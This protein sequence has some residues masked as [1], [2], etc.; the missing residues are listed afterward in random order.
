MLNT[1]SHL[2]MALICCWWLHPAQVEA[3]GQGVR[4]SEGPGILSTK[5]DKTDRAEILRLLNEGKRLR[6]TQTGAAYDSAFAVLDSA[7][8]LAESRFGHSDST[9]AAAL[10]GLANCYSWLGDAALRDSLLEEAK[11]IWQRAYGDQSPPVAAAITSQAFFLPPQGKLLQAEEQFTRAIHI[12][13]NSSGTYYEELAQ[14]QH[15]LGWVALNLDRIPQADSMCR[16]AL[17]NWIRFGGDRCWGAGTEHLQLGVI[18]RSAG[19][20]AEAEQHLRL[21]LDILMD[22]GPSEN[23]LI[24]VVQTEF[25]SLFE[26]QQRFRE[27]Q[28]YFERAVLSIERTFTPTA[29]RLVLPLT[30]LAQCERNTGSLSQAR[31][32]YERALEISRDGGSVPDQPLQMSILGDLAEVE[33]LL[34]DVQKSV[35]Y[36]ESSAAS[37]QQFLRDVFSF[38]PEDLKLQFAQQY[39]PISDQLLT[40]A[41]SKH[42]AAAIRPA[43]EMV[44]KGKALLLDA[45]TEQRAAVYCSGD[46]T[47]IRLEQ[48]RADICG[49]IAGLSHSSGQGPL[50]NRLADSL[51]RMYHVKDSLELRLGELCETFRDVKGMSQ[52]TLNDVARSLEAGTA[53]C[54]FVSYQP[55]PF[56][57]WGDASR[58]TKH[59]GVFAIS[60]DGRVASAD[61]GPSHSIDSLVRECHTSIDSYLSASQNTSERAAEQSLSRI[62][63]E[64]YARLLAP[65]GNL[66]DGCDRLV[67]SP[68]GELNLFPFEILRMPDGRYAIERFEITYAA[69]GRDLIRY[70]SNPPGATGYAVVMADPDFDAGNLEQY[71]AVT[72]VDL[73]MTGRKVRR[74][75]VRGHCLDQPFMRLIATGEEAQAVSS[76]LRQSM[77]MEVDYFSGEQASTTT[78]RALGR[79]PRVLHLATHGFFCPG[80]GR[81]GE[82]STAE[83]PLLFSGLAM[84]GVNRCLGRTDGSVDTLCT[85]SDDGLLTALEVSGLNLVGNE[86]TVLSACE[87]GAGA[88]ITGEGVFGLRRGLQHA[89]VQTQV[90]SI[91]PVPD[92]TTKSLIRSFYR[93]WSSGFTKSLALRQTQLDLLRERRRLAGA[94]HPLYWGGFVLVGN[95]N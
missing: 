56:Q 21:A 34:G 20:Y 87:T 35:A 64:L 45:L 8:A 52:L 72:P 46:P 48:D 16:E 89:G 94:A 78:L 63:A 14:A 19:R 39:M 42:S 25:G 38:A 24:A 29:G 60:A 26:A 68:D 7:R 66:P 54:E 6:L 49:E 80:S 3:S 41:L 55:H 76:I 36:Y 73:A 47:L 30:R 23:R 15:G 22:L 75:T 18:A 10:F 9:V 85:T 17:S 92:E 58:A 90:V 37:R 33:Y 77:R 83:N 59:Y 93:Y 71:A 44:L 57:I 65:L 91:F 51:A 13:K 84:A 53:L 74:P 12:L 81:S 32:H 88:V 4:D 62:T 5:G 69:T 11:N 79:V 40:I 2:A 27:A 61:L 43:F 50:S 31:L 70:A 86:L 28:L 67:I 82:E 95:P 1:L